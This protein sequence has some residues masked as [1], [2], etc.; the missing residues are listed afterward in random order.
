MLGSAVGTGS[1]LRLTA[2]VYD[3]RS[4][5]SRGSVTVDGAA[6]DLSLA[7]DLAQALLTRGLLPARS[8]PPGLPGVIT[9][10]FPAFEEYLEGER[11]YRGGRFEAAGAHFARAAEL[12]TMFAR[13]VYRAWV[14]YD[15]ARDPA[16][17]EYARRADAIAVSY[18]H[19]TLPTNREV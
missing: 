8:V 4:G 10:S 13:A 12:D 1:T 17:F 16:R 19:L 2:R 7:D 5:E 14:S 18:T 9:R 11:E 15:Y 3:V 6:E